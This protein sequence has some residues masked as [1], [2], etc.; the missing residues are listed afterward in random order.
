MKPT[1]TRPDSRTSVLLKD[2]LFFLREAELSGSRDLEI[3]GIEYDSRRVRPGS[4]FVAIRGEKTDGHLYIPQALEKGASA[5]VCQLPRD[6]LPAE[7]W[8]ASASGGVAHILVPDT[9]EALAM[10]SAAFYN[11]PQE[12]LEVFGITGT[13]G[14]T[15]TAFLLK[16]ILETAGEKVGLLT[17]VGYSWREERM[18]AS[19]TTPESKDLQEI[20]WKMKGVGVTKVAM[21]VSSHSLEMKRTFGVDFRGAVF[22]NLTQDH[23][24][25]HKDMDGYFKAKLKLFEGLEASSFAVLN[26]DDPRSA[27]IAKALRAFHLTYGLKESSQISASEIKLSHQGTSFVLSTPRWREKVSLQLLGE[28]NI[29]NALAAAG[30]AYSLDYPAEQIAFGLGSLENVPGRAERVDC[31]QAFTVLVDYAHTPE[32]LRGIIKLARSLCRRRII[33]IFGCGGD[34]DRAKRPLMGKIASELSDL[35]IVTSDNPRSEA[36]EKI[37]TDIL[38]GIS[39]GREVLKIPDRK[40]AI[41]EG[42]RLA[43]EGDGVIIAGKGHEEYLVVGDE[44]FRFSDKEIAENFLRLR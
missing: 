27:Q 39:A 18:V 41:K 13:N 31:G 42:I 11:H 40:E 38:K 9:R 32:A 44:I 20:L 3:T 28:F 22:T 34:R 19:H 43:K 21:E 25:F 2:L 1:L 30:V 24:D 15:T 17:T 29:Y 4:L 8:E 5:V 26:S 14:K 7:T 10:L 36:P 37:I 16:S 23:L 33:T 6:S 12:D 35:T